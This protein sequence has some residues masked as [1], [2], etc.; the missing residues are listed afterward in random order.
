[1]PLLFQY[2]VMIVFEPVTTIKPYLSST[3]FLAMSNASFKFLALWALTLTFL[4]SF[5]IASTS[6]FG[7][8]IDVSLARFTGQ[9]ITWP[10]VF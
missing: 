7:L 4:T 8:S 3:D 10:E 5:V 9:K 1:M 6:N 2:S